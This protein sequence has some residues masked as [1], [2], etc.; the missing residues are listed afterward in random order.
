MLA[1]LLKRLH[2]LRDRQWEAA[3]TFK[4]EIPGE[5]APITAPF[6]HGLRIGTRRDASAE[7]VD[8]AITKAEAIQPG[9][10]ALGGEKRAALLEAAADEFEAHTDEILSLCQLEAGKTIVDSVLELREAVDFLRYYA[11]EARRLF[12]EPTPLPGPTGE[13][14]YLKLAG[15]GVFATISP[16]N[17]PL[18]IFTGQILANLAAGNAVVAKPAEQTSLLA[19]RAVELMHQAGIPR[20]AIQLLPGTG[21][22]VGSGLTSDARVTGVC[23]TGSTATA[24][25]INKALDEMMQR[26]HR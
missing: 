17:F 13:E 1:P 19:F 23:F 18:A 26:I 16:W 10:N 9:W 24:Q 7:E 2:N 20:A 15:R 14:N 4:A 8:M 3:P 6:D 25:R 5:I 21:A 22:T 11:T 12:A